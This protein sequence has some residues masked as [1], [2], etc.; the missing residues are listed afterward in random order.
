[1]ALTLRQLN[2]CR[3]ATGLATMSVVLRFAA[4]IVRPDSFRVPTSNDVADSKRALSDRQLMA[5]AQAGDTSCFEALFHRYQAALLRVAQSR[6][7][8][9]DW[10]EDAVQETFLCAFKSRH[11]YDRRY[12]FRTWLWTILLNRCRNHVRRRTRAPTI[13]LWADQPCDADRSACELRQFESEEP[14]PAVRLMAKERGALLE[15]L[16]DRLSPAQADALRL[17]FFG[18]LKYQEIADAMRCS[19]ATAKNRVRWGLLRLAHWLRS[20]A[21]LADAFSLT[22]NSVQ[23]ARAPRNDA[24]EGS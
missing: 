12:N 15:S 4:A 23:F 13:H 24:G 5:R 10:A 6:L 21:S 19:L 3:T 11:T 18:G 7:G 8:Q 2:T 1:M 14:G 16:L 22:E 17:R 20:E 9:R